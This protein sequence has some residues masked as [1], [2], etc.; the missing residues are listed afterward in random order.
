[1]YPA[2]MQMISAERGREMRGQAAAWR[3]VRESRGTVRARSARIG[4][5]LIV[6][7]ARSLA[8]QQRLHGPAAA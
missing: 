7:N 8:G 5:A 3:R 4:F 2:I 1:M 6:R